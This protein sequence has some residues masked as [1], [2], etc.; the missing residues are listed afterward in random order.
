MNPSRPYLIVLLAVLLAIPLMIAVVR[1]RER[2]NRDAWHKLELGRRKRN[3]A[4]YRTWQWLYGKPRVPRISDHRLN[5]RRAG[6]P[7]TD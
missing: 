4:E 5:K 1:L 6:P 7:Q 3:I 2:R